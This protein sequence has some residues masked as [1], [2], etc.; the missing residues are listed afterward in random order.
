MMAHE[1]ENIPQGGTHE[2][3]ESSTDPSNGSVCPTYSGGDNICQNFVNDHLR[4]H[5]IPIICN[6]PVD[7]IWY[8]KDGNTTRVAESLDFIPGTS[9]AP[10]SRPSKLRKREKRQHETASSDDKLL[11]PPKVPTKAKEKSGRDGRGRFSR[12]NT[13]RFSDESDTDAS[14]VSVEPTIQRNSEVMDLEAACST[15]PSLSTDTSVAGLERTGI[16]NV[17]ILLESIRKSK[18]LK[19]TIQRTMKEAAE[20]MRSCVEMLAARSTTEETC[21]LQLEI[22]RLRQQIGAQDKEI[23]ALKEEMHSMRLHSVNLQRQHPQSTEKSAV[24]EELLRSVIDRVGK[25]LDA[26]MAGIEDRLLPQVNLRPPLAADRKKAA[27]EKRKTAAAV[28]SHSSET[29][30][31]MATQACVSETPSAVQ[32]QHGWQTASNRKKERKNK[33]KA[34]ATKEAASAVLGNAQRSSAQANGRKK[35]TRKRRKKLRAPKS[36]ALVLTLQPEAVEKGLTYKDVLTKAR[37]AANHE[38]NGITDIRYRRAATGARLFEFMGANGAAEADRVAE[39]LRQVFPEGI[40]ISRPTKCAE[41][42]IVGLDDSVTEEVIREAVARRTGCSQEAVRVSAIRDGPG[43]AGTARVR[44]PVASAKMLGEAG[45]LL[46]GWSSAKVQVLETKPIRC[47]KC[48]GSGHTFPQCTSTVDYSGLCFRCGKQGHISNTCTANPHCLSC[49]AA[50][51]PANHVVGGKG[52]KAPTRPNRGSTTA[53]TQV[54]PH[55]E[56]ERP[57]QR[58]Q[59]VQMIIDHP[60]GSSQ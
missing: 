54:T 55:S 12:P 6:D 42:R 11:P 49:E 44:C 45:R 43:G 32:T 37:Q 15:L 41:L 24:D 17:E 16:Q 35:K 9:A 33:K 47:Y 40:W 4:E 8:K 52:C 10:V 50:K 58:Q 25:M 29:A 26:R 60:N 23:A 28:T 20:K 34:A 38:E 3:G 31:V 27:Q 39:K 53:N 18:N 56:A 46:V 2:V 7:D 57:N 36:A 51:L 5:R 59:E 48:M 30:T 14:R 13:S 21:R 1:R 22:Q 19:G